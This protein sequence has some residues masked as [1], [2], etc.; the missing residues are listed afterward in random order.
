MFSYTVIHAGPRKCNRAA[1]GVSFSI[2]EKKTSIYRYTQ[3]PVDFQLP[4]WEK[5][6]RVWEVRERVA[7]R[8]II[9][10]ITHFYITQSRA[11]K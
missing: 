8:F 10:L 5:Q 7:K 9:E 11:S 4:E 1:G 6:L 2:A 3:T